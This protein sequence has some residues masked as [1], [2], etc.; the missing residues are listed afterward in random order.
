MFSVCRSFRRVFCLG[1]AFLLPSVAAAADPDLAQT[2]I[3]EIHSL[4]AMA[5]VYKDWQ[6]HTVSGHNIGAVLVDP[7]GRP[8]FWARNARFATGNGTEHGEVR[9]IRNYL[10][11]PHRVEYLGEQSPDVY[12]HAE[13]GRGFTLYTTLEPCVMCTGMMLMTRLSRAVFVQSDPDYGRVTERLTSAGTLPPYPVTLDIRQA[14][15]PE[16]RLLDEQYR[17]LGQPN[18]IIPY[19]RSESAR[20]IFAG[21][22]ERLR[23][24]RSA[25]GNQPVVEAALH[26][27]DTVVDD[28]YQADPL[29]ECPASE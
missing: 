15:M 4:L 19:L 8:V 29:Q 14:D 5:V 12:P 24:F 16:A 27:L 22:M 9:L 1:I 26:F 10:D 11:C 2:E 18:A 6:A 23:R 3:D 21:A 28:G 25:H 13:P 20:R 17:R 7:A